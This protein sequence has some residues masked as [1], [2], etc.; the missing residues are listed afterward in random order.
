MFRHN[1]LA[2]AIA[3]VAVAAAPLAARAAP[4]HAVGTPAL[5]AVYTASNDATT[6]SILVF[7]RQADGR[8]VPGT[9]VDTGGRGSGSGLGNQ[10]GVRLTPDERWLLVVNAGSNEVSVLGVGE[11]SLTFADVV[12]SNGSQPISV[13]ANRDL[14]YVVN[15]GSDSIAG[16]RLDPRGHLVS[17]AGSG[18]SLGGSGTGPAEIAFSPDGNFLVVTEKNTNKIAVFPVDHDGLAGVPLVQDSS[19]TTP[20]GF[21][22]GKRGQLFVSEA[23]GGAAD[24]SATSSYSLGSDGILTAI[25]PSAADNE[26]SACWSAISPDGRFAYISNTG[27]GTISGYRVDFDGHIAL[28]DADG[29]TGTTGGKP[30][31]LAFTQNGQFLYDLAGGTNKLAGF[32]VRADG[33]LEALPFLADVPATANGLAVR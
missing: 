3:A 12:S 1:S 24:A 18:Q 32:R 11:S 7:D 27:S 19:G 17:L 25:T 6:N 4:A 30:S 5:G 26:S 21:A 29:V 31:D 9:S 8:L 33:S 28:I 13:A 15:A 14:V 2:V 10:G 16:F 20:F 22:F 23:F